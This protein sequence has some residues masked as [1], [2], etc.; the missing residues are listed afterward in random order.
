MLGVEIPGYS[1]QERCEQR[2]YG[3]EGDRPELRRERDH[4]KSEQDGRAK[5]DNDAI[6]RLRQHGAG[7]RA[8]DHLGVDFHPR[9]GRGNRRGLDVVEADRRRSDQH[10][11]ARKLFGRGGPREHIGRGDKNRAIM[12]RKVNPELAVAIGR[13]LE[14]LDADAL[15]AGLIGLDEDRVGAGR[16]PQHFEAQRRHGLALGQHQHRHPPDDAVA[17]LPD[18]EQAPTGGGRFENRNV[19][20][21]TGPLEHEGLGF[22]A[23]HREARHR[24]RL[25]EFRLDFR[26]PGFAEHHARVPHDIGEEL[27]VA[28]QRAQFFAGHLVEIAKRV[29][30]HVRIEPVGLGEYDVEGDHDRAKLGQRSDHIRDPRP[31]PRPLAELRG[32]ALVVDIDNGHRSRLLHARIDALEGIEGSHAKLLDRRGIGDAQRG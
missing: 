11:L 17:F 9:H 29:G 2:T 26:K 14:T 20:Q 23:E 21:Q 18:R 13:D 5:F 1:D 6:T 15:D 16:H 4:Q 8:L 30:R 31:R 32:Q 28:R 19:A 27:I 10:Q 3:D 25:V 12:M 24:Q 7:Q 22:L